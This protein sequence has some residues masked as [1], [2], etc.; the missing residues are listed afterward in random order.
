MATEILV[1]NGTATV[2]AD[3]TD[4]SSSVTGLARTHQIDLTSLA[5]GS[6]RQGAKAD[7]GATRARRYAVFAAIEF[8]TAPSSGDIVD[9]WWASSP[10]STAGNANPGGT[11]GTDAAY[12]GTAGDSLD[13]SIKQCRFIGSLVCTAD[14]TTVVQYQYIGVLEVIDRYGMPI[15]D[16]NADQAFEDDAVEM[17]IAL[18][19]IIDES[20]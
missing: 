12:T 19:P 3:T 18:I 13:D 1:K 11:N 6:A 7:L 8:I 10:S 14:A 5:S 17:C 2:W 16:N 4:Y 15:V 20:Q 9:I